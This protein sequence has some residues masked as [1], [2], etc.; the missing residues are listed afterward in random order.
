LNNAGSKKKGMLARAAALLRAR[1]VSNVRAFRIDLSWPGSL[2]I[3][4][5]SSRD[6]A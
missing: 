5:L 3:V 1:Q 6:L 2:R 4:T